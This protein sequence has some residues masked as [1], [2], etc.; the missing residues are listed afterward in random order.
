MVLVYVQQVFSSQI[1]ISTSTGSSPCEWK[2]PPVSEISMDSLSRFLKELKFP[3]ISVI[4]TVT[5]HFSMT[6]IKIKANSECYG[7][8]NTSLYRFVQG[9]S[10]VWKGNRKANG[11]LV[12]TSS[13]VKQLQYRRKNGLAV[14]VLY[15]TQVS[16][17]LQ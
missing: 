11:Y 16:P 13:P 17:L 10:Y 3:T 12:Q 15:W 8:R 4:S 1:F 7:Q 6:S 2:K 5:I 14:A 9:I